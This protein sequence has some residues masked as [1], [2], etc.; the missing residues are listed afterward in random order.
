MK[1]LVVREEGD[2]EADRQLSKAIL[3]QVTVSGGT[4]WI[5][6]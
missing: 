2:E 6:Q 3:G 5:D 4:E 1:D